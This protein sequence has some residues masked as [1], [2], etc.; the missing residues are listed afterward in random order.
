MG[1]KEGGKVESEKKKVEAHPE[2][3]KKAEAH[4][5][6]KK[7]EAHPVEKKAEAH[8]AEKK[9]DE[10]EK[11]KKEE[12]PITVVLKV[13]MHC[14]GC[15]RKVRHAVKGFGGIESVSTDCNSNKL[16]VV[17]KVDPW[18]VRDQ[19]EGKLHKPVALVSPN[20]PR[21]EEKPTK[22]EKKP[23]EKKPNK[24][25][26]P[27]TVVLKIRLHCEGCTQRIRKTISKVKGVEAVDI[28]K[29]KEE[30]TVKGTMDG[31]ALPELL[32]QK[33]KRPVAVVAPKKDD[34]K[35]EPKKEDAAKESG[36]AAKESGGA[37]KEAAKKMEYRGQGDFGG[38]NAPMPYAAYMVEPLHAP[39]YFSDEN[40]NAC[41]VM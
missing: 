30:V 38:F 36:G 18:K 20:I 5:A 13:D 34:G 19:V 8:P 21:K 4:P 29:G 22:E 3:K 33:L 1:E 6:E 35:K 26:T 40:P 31:K 39:Q 10:G 16:T 12:G 9:K 14:E 23:D 17:G 2:E 24:P 25:P 11:N 28:D 15:A 32:S 7:A 27:T 37:A 41:A